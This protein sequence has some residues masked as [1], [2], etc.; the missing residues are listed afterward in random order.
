VPVTAIFDG[1]LW[2]LASAGSVFWNGIS[3]GTTFASS[4]IDLSKHIALYGSS[5]GLD[6]TA[7]AINVLVN[8]TTV[9]TAVFGNGAIRSLTIGSGSQTTHS[10]VYSDGAAG[11]LRGVAFRTVPSAG[12]A[13]VNR[14]GV[15]AGSVAESGTNNTGSDLVITRY[16]DAGANIDNPLVITRTSGVV[17]I[18]PGGLVVPAGAGI[19]IGPVGTAPNIH[20]G[21]GAA[22]G[23]QPSGSIWVRTDGTAGARI[24]VSQGG[25]TWVPIASV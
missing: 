15:Y 9:P 16:T 19:T 13:G 10:F 22:V 23:T 3:F 8:D 1:T 6:V 2:H 11:L 4:A 5:Y 25:G 7:N 18:G 20:S 21:T 12:A 17:T 24:Y 14:W